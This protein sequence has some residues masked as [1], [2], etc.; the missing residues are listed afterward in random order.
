MAR[1]GRI[2]CICAG[3]N[4][5]CSK[6][7]GRGY[8]SADDLPAAR[9]IK[10]KNTPQSLVPLIATIHPRKILTKCRFCKSFVAKKNLRKHIK[11]VHGLLHTEIW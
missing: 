2:I 10:S 4:P 5:Q 7:E 3:R 8:Y 1:E 11:K 9:F 6:C